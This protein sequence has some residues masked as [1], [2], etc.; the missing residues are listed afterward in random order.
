MSASKELLSIPN[1]VFLVTG[2]YFAIVAGLNEG[3]PYTAIGAVLCFIA[4]GLSFAKDLFFAAPW[5]LA[6]TAFSIVVLLAQ[7]AADFTVSNA[8]AAVVASVLINGVLFVLDLGVLIWTAKDM[9]TR[10]APEEEEE[11]EAK[12]KKLT[13]EI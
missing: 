11:P 4:V 12:K 9:T 5:R 8:S 10:E 1:I 3:S 6:T 13:Y 7:V 2:V